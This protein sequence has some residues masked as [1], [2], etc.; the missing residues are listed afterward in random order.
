M[1][2]IL[3][4]L[5]TIS[6]ISSCSNLRKT[7]NLQSKLK[8]VWKEY[9]QES[10]DESKEIEVFIATNRRQ[11]VKSFGCSNKS[12][13]VDLGNEIKFGNCKVNIA[14]IRD[15][16]NVDVNSS[17]NSFVIMAKRSLEE[18]YFMKLIK[19]SKATP[20]I[21]IHGFNTL[22]QEAILRASQI[23]YDLKYQGPIILYSWPAGSEGFLNSK[24]IGKTYEYNLINA[25]YSVDP[26]VRFLTRLNDNGIKPNLMVHSMGNQIVLPAL[27]R[28]SEKESNITVNELFLNAPD[29]TSKGF[30]DLINNIKPIVNHITLYCS[31]H[32]NAIATS[33]FFNNDKRVGQC[34]KV[35]DV[36]VINVSLIDNASS[37][38]GHDYYA[39]RPI[40]NDIFMTL[41]GIDVEKRLFIS[42][43]ADNR[44]EK[45]RMRR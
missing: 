25:K 27:E 19:R 45:Y 35:E 34:I 41:L 21:F 15:V 12:F 13:G 44:P 23:A 2:K 10:F 38:L 26:F 14:K 5:L 42:K 31:Y 40:L 9:F 28:I 24:F 16:G 22:Y 4:F 6:V 17:K 30:D 18:D 33:T 43:T 20:L 37:G 11:K 3:L 8:P 7:D 39:S 1:K 29:I 36:D 32:D